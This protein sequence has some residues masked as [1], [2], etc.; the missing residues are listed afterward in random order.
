[1]ESSTGK[2]HEQINA[3]RRVCQTL[4][5]HQHICVGP[6]DPVLIW[7]RSV[8]VHFVKTDDNFYS[9]QRIVKIGNINTIL[10]NYLQ[11][12][13][14]SKL[15]EA[16]SKFEP[17][18]VIC[19]DRYWRF[20]SPEKIS[21]CCPK[22]NG[23]TIK[24]A[25]PKTNVNLKYISNGFDEISLEECQRL[26]EEHIMPVFNSIPDDTKDPAELVEHIK[27]LEKPLVTFIPVANILGIN[28]ISQ[29]KSANSK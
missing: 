4:I 20:L 11:D 1:M 29:V 8:G 27:L 13:S 17:G 10:L 3:I 18:S 7:F 22:L 16:A 26:Y 6:D 5:G 19:L 14:I 28:Q 21:L 23:C 2:L 9:K 12:L 15:I 24:I 25:Q